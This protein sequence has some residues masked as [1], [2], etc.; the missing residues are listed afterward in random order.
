MKAVEIRDL[1]TEELEAKSRE[2]R[3]ELFNVKV[4]RSTGQLESTAL[5]MQLRRD[6]ARVETVLREKRGAT[7]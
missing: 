5:L 1:A 4:K 6:I 3:G 7:K 2:L